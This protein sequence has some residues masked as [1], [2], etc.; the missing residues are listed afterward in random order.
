V[1]LHR[2]LWLNIAVMTMV[3][4]LDKFLKLNCNFFI[5]SF[6]SYVGAPFVIY[7]NRKV[8]FKGIL[9]SKSIQNGENRCENKQITA[10][11]N[12]LQFKNW[13]K[14]ILERYKN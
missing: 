6:L 7:S 13:I 9:I 11:T 5:F 1:Q 10:F 14:E 8:T 4:F 3:K 2:N 12:I